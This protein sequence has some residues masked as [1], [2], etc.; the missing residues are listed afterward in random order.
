MNFTGDYW[1][2]FSYP[3]TG[4]THPNNTRWYYLYNATR[5]LSK[6]IFPNGS[7]PLF[8]HVRVA[9]YS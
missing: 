2:K 6:Q 9:A 1:T 7:D 5:E 4:E 3:N 8:E